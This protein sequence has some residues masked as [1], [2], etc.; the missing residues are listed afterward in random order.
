ME[1]HSSFPDDVGA[2]I[3][4]SFTTGKGV[5]TDRDENVT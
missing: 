3:I 4:Y 5:Y 1:F 2:L